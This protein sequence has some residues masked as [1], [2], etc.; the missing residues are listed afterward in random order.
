MALCAIAGG[1]AY[2]ISGR[3]WLSAY[4][5]EPA[6]H[7]RGESAMWLALIGLA[8]LAGLALLVVNR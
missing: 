7:W 2:A 3:R 4:R 8:A 6:V 1:A 5:A